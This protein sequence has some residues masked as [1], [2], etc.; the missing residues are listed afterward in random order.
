MGCCTVVFEAENDELSESLKLL[1]AI[2]AAYEPTE[3]ALNEYHR[4]LLDEKLYQNF[5][6]KFSCSAIRLMVDE[7]RK[8]IESEPTAPEFL[9]RLIETLCLEGENE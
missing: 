4:F 7:L 9:K 5:T 3:Y 2:L 6:K 1:L 8:E